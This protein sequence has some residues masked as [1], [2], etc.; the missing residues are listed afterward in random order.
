MAKTG[1]GIHGAVQEHNYP[2][3]II[4]IMLVRNSCHATL[5]KPTLAHQELSVRCPRHNFCKYML[6][7]SWNDAA[8]LRWRILPLHC[9]SFA[10]TR[11]CDSKGSET[12]QHKVGQMGR[13]QRWFAAT[14][15][16]SSH[17]CIPGHMQRCKR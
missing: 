14:T 5:L 7:N 8:R 11:L 9:V 3:K 4:V 16:T 1:E 10:T 13:Q 2:G 6:K 17:S 12:G 15:T